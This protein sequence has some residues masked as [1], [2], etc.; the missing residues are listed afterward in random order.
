MPDDAVKR[1]IKSTQRKL[2]RFTTQKAGEA[3]LVD[4]NRK[5]RVNSLVLSS[6]TVP[7]TVQ[8]VLGRAVSKAS[9]EAATDLGT[10]RCTTVQSV[11]GSV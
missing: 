8:L 11:T 7:L 3:W 1:W 10:E 5:Q 9:T 6:M 4:P 2:E